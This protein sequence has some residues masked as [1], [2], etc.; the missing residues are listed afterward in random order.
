MDTIQ[1]RKSFHSWE[2]FFEKT[3]FLPALPPFRQASNRGFPL[4][5]PDFQGTGPTRENPLFYVSQ[6]PGLFTRRRL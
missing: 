1:R 4:A 2:K 6:R 3:G 5:D